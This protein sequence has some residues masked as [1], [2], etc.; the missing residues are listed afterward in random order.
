MMKR[1]HTLLKEGE[2]FKYLTLIVVLLLFQS[3][4]H[5]QDEIEIKYIN[6]EWI[7]KNCSYED[8]L[9]KNDTL[10]FELQNSDQQNITPQA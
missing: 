6:S 8:D 1:Y 7:I 10:E 2:C 9:F 4:I 3:H 5:C